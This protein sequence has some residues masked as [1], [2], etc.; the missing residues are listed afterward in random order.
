MPKPV[1]DR[2]RPPL[3][4]LAYAVV[5]WL[6]AWV[7]PR[8]AVLQQ[9]REGYGIVWA[10][11]V[12]VVSVAFVAIALPA[13]LD[14]TWTL[15]FDGFSSPL[16]LILSNASLTLRSLTWTL[17]DPPEL[18]RLVALILV[19]HGLWVVLAW[20]HLPWC[21]QP[22]TPTD[23][24]RQALRAVSW[25]SPAAVLASTLTL[26]TVALWDAAVDA[27]IQNEFGGWLEFYSAQAAATQPPKPPWWVSFADVG[28]N[29]LLVTSLLTTYAWLTAAIRAVPWPAR[30]RWP[31]RCTD[32]GYSLQGVDPAGG[33]PECGH[34]VAKSLQPDPL[35]PEPTPGRTPRFPAFTH[36]FRVGRTALR[37]PHR[38]GRATT[39]YSLN[40]QHA[41]SRWITGIALFLTT[42]AG[43][44]A[45]H[46]TLASFNA[47][48]GLNDRVA[49][50]YYYALLP[51]FS[52]LGLLT[53][54]QFT[55]TLA[56]ATYT[57]K[58]AGS[59]LP[60]AAA[61]A[62]FGGLYL[63]IASAYLWALVA[64]LITIRHTLDPDQILSDFVT[65][66]FFELSVIAVPI[67]AMIFWAG[68]HHLLGRALRA[69]RFNNH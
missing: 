47:D 5:L 59:T 27:R 65:F 12:A 29:L 20:V 24:L 52:T 53:V 44:A 67:I 1:K 33:C 10:W 22:G 21:A 28:P 62:S 43:V 13:L 16:P 49:I 8:Q 31:P 7:R 55:A 3:D 4:R 25:A 19:G 34:P 15:A 38:L 41:A 2:R 57:R 6:T 66:N 51:T 58:D 37:H 32:C 23:A 17:S 69:A 36:W 14:W 56:A 68:Y 60:A 39:L 61:F 54:M 35:F 50:V 18:A 30:S 63:V 11:G 48:R 26:C 46:A 45:T 64:L 40:T 9:H 42:L